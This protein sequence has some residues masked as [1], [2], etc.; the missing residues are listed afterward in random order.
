MRRLFLLLFL[1]G[2]GARG[3]NRK[4]TPTS[5]GEKLALTLLFY[6]LFGCLAFT[7]GS[8]P[9][10]ALSAYL[11]AMT[12]VFLGMFVASSAGEIL[13]NREEAD[14]LLHRPI[15]PRTMLWAKIRVLVE[16]SLWLAGAFNLA[17]LFIGLNASDGGWRFPIIHAISTAISALFCTGSIVLMY[18]LCLRWFGRERLEGVMTAAQVLVS[19]AVVLSGQVLPRVVFKLGD[20]MT[21]NESSWWLGLLPPAWFAGFDDAFAGSASPKS[22]LFAAIALSVTGGILWLAFGKLAQSYETGLQAFNETV[23]QKKLKP[24][25]RRLLERLAEIPPLSWWLRDHVSRASFLLTAAYLVRDRDLKLRLYPGIAP[26]MIFPLVFLFQ[27]AGKHGTFGIAFA[28]GYLGLI[29]LMAL[30]LVE[31][32]QQWQASDLFRSAPLA[33]PGAICNGARRAILLFLTLPALLV[34]ILVVLAV[35]GFDGQL[36]LLIPGLISLPVF[37]LWPS[38][39]GRSVPFSKPAE[40]SK[41]AGRGLTMMVVMFL[42]MGLSGGAFFAWSGGWFAIYLAIEASVAAAAYLALRRMIGSIPWDSAE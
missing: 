22:F 32:S 2:R 37:A 10:F 17:G 11:H 1:R 9:V 8:Q 29:P 15:A 5:I 7:F 33:G 3:L 6:G 42:S 28:G 36:L 20:V 27:G 4:A 39:I 24:T 16:V 30:G 12:F 19:I 23:S 34:S 18:Q 38:A 25:R 21:L 35:Q 41:S 31:Y 14:I 13:F 40:E 26:M